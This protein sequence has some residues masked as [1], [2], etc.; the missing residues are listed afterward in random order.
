MKLPKWTEE[1]LT[2][3]LDLYLKIK[4]GEKKHS[5]STF[6][7]M[8]E[9]LRSLNIHPGLN[10][11]PT[12]RNANGISRKLG[13]FS[14][15]D[16]DYAG[17]GLYACSMLDKEIFMK[18]YKK[19]TELKRAVSDIEKKHL[20]QKKE[21]RK[22][23]PWKK[24]ELIL[25]LAL[26]KVLT[27]GQMHG[28]NPKVIALSRV[29]NELPLY[30]KNIRSENFRSIASV[31]LRL[32]NFRSCDPKCNTKGLLSSGTG[33][34]KEIFNEYCKKDKLLASAV[35]DIEKKYNV[36]IQHLLSKDKPGNIQDKMKRNDEMDNNL[37]QLHKSK[38][39]DTSFYRKVKEYHYG[40]SGTCSV[41]RIKLN[42]IYG[43]LGEDIME[44]H[45]I[46]RFST[47]KNAS[48]E[49]CIGD[50]IQ[51]CPACHKLLDKHYGLIEHEELK[52]IIRNQ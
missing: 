6:R 17:K 39:V 37:Y 13:N 3:T 10:E 28:T 43:K 46:K 1:E 32:S 18:F 22:Q 44:Y 7:E 51:V 45:C 31:S 4:R 41:C 29:L 8:S 12:F 30:E 35:A 15:I 38:E 16:P 20:D 47:D 27:F 5:Y 11:N 48:V 24:E 14:A 19:P 25:T 52:N 42:N 26:Y 2:L 49:V 34:F 33:L 50:Y 21:N 40:K 23:L 9:K 36:N